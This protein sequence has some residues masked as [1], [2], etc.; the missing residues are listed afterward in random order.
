MVMF[1]K[2]AVTV[3]AAAFVMLAVALA[4]AVPTALAIARPTTTNGDG[5]FVQP[6]AQRSCAA[7]EDWFLNP[8]CRQTHIKKVARTKRAAHNASR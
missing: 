6:L 3:L 1:K 2:I 4:P 8:T 7:F 5:K